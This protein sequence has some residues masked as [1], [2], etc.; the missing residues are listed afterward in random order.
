MNYL[1]RARELEQ[2]II[3][4]RRDIH[5]HPELGFEETRTARLVADNLR[6]MGLEVEVGVGITGVV[7]RIGDGNGPK[8]GIRADMDALPI[9]EENDV[10]YK[11]QTPGVM[12]ACGH[13]A[14]TAILL[15]VAKM[16]N[17]TDDLPPGEIR[18]LFQ[19]SEERW[20]E[21]GHSGATRMIEDNALEE[22]DAVIALHVASMS[23]SGTVEVA[24]GHF[25]AAVD[26]FFATIIGEGA[27]G[28]SPH[29]GIDPIFIL[30]QVINAVQGIRSRRLNPTE[31]SVVTIG[32]V[33]AGVAPNVIPNEVKLS[34]TIRSY[35][36]ETRSQ[37]H[38]ELEK[39]FGVTRALGGDYTL[40]ISRGYPSMY[41]DPHVAD[42]VR[43]VSRDTIGEENTKEKAKTMGAEDFAYMAQK[44]PGAMFNLGVQLDDIKRPHHS[45]I[46]D[47]DEHALPIGAAVLAESAVR[48]LREKA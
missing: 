28:A 33:H 22:L 10:P 11:S 18:F 48:L 6:E 35:N 15:S 42:L 38:E 23:P 2:Q 41:N 31:P 17:E 32:S 27:H 43:A 30:G 4:W 21:E 9:Q 3:D 8:I 5:A 26:S 45:P 19:P 44:A 40:H 12:H 25:M 1:E 20:D 24:D 47:I 14:H 34:G 36:E 46:F 16:L 7:A 37:I 13:D 29:T 39:A